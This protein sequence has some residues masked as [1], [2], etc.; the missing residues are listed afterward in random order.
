MCRIW[1]SKMS[2]L[3]WF[4]RDEKSWARFTFSGTWKSNYYFD[5]RTFGTRSIFSPGAKIWCTVWFKSSPRRFWCQI[6]HNF[7]QLEGFSSVG[8]PWF[9]RPYLLLPYFTAWF[10]GE[11]EPVIL[12]YYYFRCLKVFYIFDK[13]STF[14]FFLE[15]STPEYFLELNIGFVKILWISAMWTGSERDI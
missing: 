11:A 14:Q 2:A 10:L 12:L 8:P 15:N 3:R 5:L 1:D 4:E 7:P 9:E 13:S 6:H